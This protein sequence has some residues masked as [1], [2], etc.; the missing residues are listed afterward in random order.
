MPARTNDFQ[1]LVHRIY[2]QLN[3]DAVVTESALLQAHDGT[4]REVDILIEYRVADVPMRIAVE[5]RD[6]RRSSDIQWIDSLLGKYRDLPVDRIIA[7]SKNGFSKSARRKASAH[8]IELRSLRSAMSADWPK[9]LERVTP[10]S[11]LTGFEV[12]S[13]V[14]NSTPP[15]PGG[16]D[17]AT[18]AVVDGSPTTVHALVRDLITYVRKALIPQQLHSYRSLAE[19]PKVLEN[20]YE[21]VLVDVTI[22]LADGTT[23]RVSSCEISARTHVR[24]EIV[25]PGQELL[26]G[27]VGVTIASHYVP[28]LDELAT[29]TITQTPGERFV[30]ISEEVRKL[31]TGELTERTHET[32]S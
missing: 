5:C 11:V 32:D 8:R 19:M 30:R 25:E 3:D 4:R 6:H 12:L 17:P 7:V 16:I 9:E 13:V 24:A 20:T 27:N 10:V 15:L 21:L 23:Y 29:V 31:T 18:A 28:E 1:Q 14:F 22:V 2:A 26:L